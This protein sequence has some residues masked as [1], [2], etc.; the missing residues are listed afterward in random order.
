MITTVFKSHRTPANKCSA[1]SLLLLLVLFSACSSSAPVMNNDAAHTSSSENLEQL[2]W[3]RLEE[4][5]TK[6]TQAD[7]D[8]MTGM[9]GHH[10][11]ALIMSELAPKNGASSEIRVLT[12]RI[13]NAQKDEIATMQNWLRERG[14]TVPEIHIDGTMLM[15]HGGG[16]HS[17]HMPGMLTQEQL[18]ELRDARGLDY[19]ILFLKYMIQHHQ[20]A[21]SM[22]K[23]LFAADGAGQDEMS[24]KVANDIQV[25]QLTEI[26]RMELMLK[27]RTN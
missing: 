24:F 25:D 6:F 23:D 17:M 21:V 10:A 18:D 16:D 11:Q 26:A 4:A 9:I 14:Q 22:V 19:D 7:V 5:K 8:F 13:I 15:V 20:G 1:L 3:D 12:A 27:A 2:F